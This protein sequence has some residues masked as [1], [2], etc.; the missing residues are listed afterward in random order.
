MTTDPAEEPAVEAPWTC[1][2]CA[3]PVRRAWLPLRH[4][5]LARAEELCLDCLLRT[6]APGIAAKIGEALAPLEVEAGACAFAAGL[7]A[8]VEARA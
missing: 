6:M 1:R 7:L 4:E 3:V 5:A 2:V 8:Y